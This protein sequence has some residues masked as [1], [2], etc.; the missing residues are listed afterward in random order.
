MAREFRHERRQETSGWTTLMREQR[1]RCT[2]PQPST[3]PEYPSVEVVA[4]QLYRRR[5]GAQ[6]GDP[7]L[8]RFWRVLTV[9]HFP[10]DVFLR[11]VRTNR[12]VSSNTCNVPGQSR[13]RGD[14]EG[15]SAWE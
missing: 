4:T 14:P 7:G 9:E 2:Y 1:Q 5:G 12:R 6:R 8:D 3:G 13:V 10:I 15:K 11:K